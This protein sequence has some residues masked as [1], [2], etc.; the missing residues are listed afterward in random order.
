MILF[1]PYNFYAL[2]NVANDIV[3]QVLLQNLE[4]DFLLKLWDIYYTRILRLSP[5]SE[6]LKNH[7]STRLEWK[8]KP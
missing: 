8:K 3:V 6:E 1:S 5:Y 4:I 7:N 2:I